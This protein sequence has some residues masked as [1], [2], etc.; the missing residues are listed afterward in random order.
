[1]NVYEVNVNMLYDLLNLCEEKEIL[2][3]EKKI[4]LGYETMNINNFFAVRTE[5]IN[6]SLDSLGEFTVIFGNT[7]SM[8]ETEWIMFDVLK[9]G[10]DFDVIK[11]AYEN[12]VE[13]EHIGIIFSFLHELGHI[14]S[15]IDAMGDDK[16]IEKIDKNNSLY[17]MSDKMWREDRD[18]MEI[19]KFYRAIPEERKADLFA[20]RMMKLYLKEILD[21]IE[22]KKIAI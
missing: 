6:H 11:I 18:L 15:Y 5:I 22:I 12:H 20:I 2:K 7:Y 19:Q 16:K 21:K 14:K 8:D 3:T 17:D 4:S 13:V 10:Y 1:M 9:M